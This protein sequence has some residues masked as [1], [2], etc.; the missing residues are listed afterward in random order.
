MKIREIM[1]P[2]AFAVGEMDCLGDA[3]EMMQRVHIRHLP[4]VKAD[5]VVGMLSQRDILA[6]RAN[7]AGG[8]WWA[9]PVSRAMQAPVQTAHPD[10]PVIEVAG[11][12]AAAK[13]GAMPVSEY[14]KLIGIATVSDVLDAEVR[15]ANLPRPGAA[16]HGSFDHVVALGASADG[17][18]A[19]K[20]IAHALPRDFPAPVLA[21]LHVGPHSQLPEILARVSHMPVLHP[22]DGEPLYPSRIYVARP[23]H[24]MR[25]ERGCVRVSRDHVDHHKP[26]ID[27]LFRTTAEAYGPAA[28]G[29]VLTGYL[30]DGAEGLKAIK[31]HRG[32]T[33]VQDPAEAGV[34]QMPL[35]ALAKTPIDYQSKLAELGPLLRM[36][37]TA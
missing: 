23:E 36:L 35:A 20:H 10:D 13:I 32:I 29:V 17:V 3:H 19:L 4:V 30:A 1:R 31:A 37:V 27:E 28:I 2:G 34:P 21:V 8:D 5:R 26:S 33:I 18:S 9:I 7:T 6:A 11:R 12:M 15:G 16:V 24:H 22:F 14:G 25:V